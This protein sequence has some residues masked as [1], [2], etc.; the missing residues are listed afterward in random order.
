MPEAE[1]ASS[2][3]RTIDHS[4]TKAELEEEFRINASPEQLAKSLFGATHRRITDIAFVARRL[5]GASE[6]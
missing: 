3:G 1:A 2:R 5:L 4:P 6:R